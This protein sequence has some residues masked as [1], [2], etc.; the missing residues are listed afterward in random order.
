VNVRPATVA[1]VPVA[2]AILDEASAYVHT[3]GFGHWHVP[4]PQDELVHRLERGE[5]YVVDVDG[6]TAAT[7]TLLWDDPAFWGERPPDA[8]YLHKLAIRRAFAGRGLGAAIVDWVDGHAASAGRR[9]VR[10]DC[11]REDPGIRSYYERLGFEHRGDKEDDPRF[12]VALYER[13]TGPFRPRPGTVTGR[14]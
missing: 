14:D 3:L 7:L 5:L 11:Q 4:F 2:A 6:Q 10:L 1:D 8:V 9:Y 13:P 12:P